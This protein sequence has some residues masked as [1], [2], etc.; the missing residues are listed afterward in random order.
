MFHVK[1]YI[2]IAADL[3][4]GCV[5]RETERFVQSYFLMADL[6]CDGFALCRICRTED[7][8]APS[9]VVDMRELLNFQ[10]LEV[11]IFLSVSTAYLYR[12]PHRIFQQWV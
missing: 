10:F 7:R 12:R 8:R 5:S 6:Q 2:L 1:Q 9:A 11:P 4:V 3:T